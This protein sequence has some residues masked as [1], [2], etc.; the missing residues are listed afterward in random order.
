M[1]VTEFHVTNELNNLTKIASRIIDN[2]SCS[3]NVK[4]TCGSYYGF[5]IVVLIKLEKCSCSSSEQFNAFRHRDIYMASKDINN[6]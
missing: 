5:V 6:Y 3:P 1:Y 2:Q 4:M